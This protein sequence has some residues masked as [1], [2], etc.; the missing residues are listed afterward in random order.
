[1]VSAIIDLSNRDRQT[2]TKSATCA[3]TG[4][5]PWY[6]Q[7]RN[8]RIEPRSAAHMLFSATGHWS[9]RSKDWA[10]E[11]LIFFCENVSLAGSEI[12]THELGA[13]A[14]KSS[15]GIGTEQNRRFPVTLICASFG[16]IAMRNP[17]G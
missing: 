5:S 1:M 9:K 13:S 14:F 8:K 7:P 12:T 10:I 17:F 6:G 16:G 11:Q 15:F 2:A 3:A 4:T